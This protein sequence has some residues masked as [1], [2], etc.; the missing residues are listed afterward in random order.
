MSIDRQRVR[1]EFAAYTRNYDPDNILIELKIIHTYKVADN[2][3]CIAR[4]LGLSDE[5]IEFNW[6]SGMLHDIG[7]FEQ[8]RRYNTYIDAQSIDHA[9]F[10]A[11]LLFG[12]ERLIDRFT[13]DRSIDDTLETVIRQHNR[14]RISEDVTGRTLTFCNILR[15]ADKV[16][17]FRV[18]IDTPMEELLGAPMSELVTA[19]VTPSVLKQILTHQAV[20]RSEIQTTADRHISHIALA[21][22][23]V[24]PMSRQLTIEQGNLYKMFDFPTENDSMKEALTTIKKEVDAFFTNE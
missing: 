6:L 16:D 15:D 4:S 14:F 22:E 12:K 11:D 17:I 19:G 18:I 21:F 8:F 9:A 1:E 7:R 10:G 20:L 23:L 3:E 5:E 2:C 13:D 24:Y